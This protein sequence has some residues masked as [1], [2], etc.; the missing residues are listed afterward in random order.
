[1]RNVIRASV[2]TLA[3]CVTAY[4]GDIP[5]PPAAPPPPPSAPTEG[6]TTEGEMPCPPL[7]VVALTLLSLF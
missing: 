4:A 7:V 3:L 5:N 6:A 1:M 2:L